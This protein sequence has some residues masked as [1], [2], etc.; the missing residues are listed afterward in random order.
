[1][2]LDP[3]RAKLVKHIKEE[4]KALA[5]GIRVG[6]RQESLNAVE[7]FRVKADELIANY[8]CIVEAM[9]LDLLKI[10]EG[11]GKVLVSEWDG[12]GRH[13]GLSLEV[14]LCSGSYSG[15]YPQISGACQTGEL[16]PGKY[17]VVLV[18]LPIHPQLPALDAR[19]PGLG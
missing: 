3:V 4:I 8:S 18:V 19:H 14:H 9:P 1:M 5:D 11:G 2:T 15:S 13:G 7:R 16:P 17:K 6:L 10:V 12:S